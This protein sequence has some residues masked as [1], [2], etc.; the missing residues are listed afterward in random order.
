ML[1]L[2]FKVSSSLLEDPEISTDALDMVTVVKGE[3]EDEDDNDDGEFKGFCVYGKK[4]IVY[5]YD[6]LH[7]VNLAQRR[8][9]H[10]SIRV[11]K[12]RVVVP[13]Q[14]RLVGPIFSWFQMASL[15]FGLGAQSGPR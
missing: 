13:I 2:C 15:G 1:T 10:K 5:G 14:Q 9:S 4:I 7:T 6:G 11:I 8:R 3:E 12:E